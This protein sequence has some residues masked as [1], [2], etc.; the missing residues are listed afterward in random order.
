[1]RGCNEQ[2]F[3]NFTRKKFLNM[4][5]TLQQ[6]KE[7]QRE[8]WNKFSSGWKKWDRLVIPW[9]E[10]V[11]TSM[12]SGINLQAHSRVL[13][14]ATGTGEPGLTAATMVPKGMVTGTD[15]AE[16]MLAIAS[17]NARRRGIENYE[18]KNCDAAAIP[19]S[20]NYF[21]AILCRNGFMFFPDV[22]LTLNELV[23]TL[24]P[25]A[26]LSIS[27]WGSPEKNNWATTIINAI[28]RYVPIPKQSID[29]PGLFRCAVPGYM[30]ERFTLARLKNVSVEEVSGTISFTS[31]DEYWEFVTEVSAPVVAL[32]SKADDS[33]R[34]KI[35]QLV[36][37][38][39]NHHS[40][41]DPVQFTWTALVIKGN[42]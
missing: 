29:S 2:K 3:P 18:T 32:L 22:M 38:T 5:P 15:L 40:Q 41:G 16:D 37:D 36:T 12:L 14:V 31:P 19:F 17:E 25:G 20:S 6:I 42:K 30:H 21:D 13:D 9:L 4:S 34:A 11:G 33:V 26:Y 27:V 35:Q 24:K 1:M 39:L 10:P 28:S 7:Q 23:R 8:S